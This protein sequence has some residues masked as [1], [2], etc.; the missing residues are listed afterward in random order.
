MTSQTILFGGS[1]FLGPIILQKYPEII[2]V[3]RTIPPKYIKNRH[4]NLPS[5]EQLSILNNLEF[6]KVIFLIGNSN[7]HRINTTS[8]MGIDYNV[9]PLKK[10]LTY[11][12]KRKLKKFV[13]FTTMLLYDVNKM[14]L[15]CDET[16]PINPFIN[17]YV[18]SKY[19]AEEVTKFYKDKVPII[20]VRLS[21][22]YGPTKL[23][24]P[25]VVPQLMHGVLKSDNPSVWTTK[26][27]R[28][29][30]YAEDASDAILKLLDTDYTGPVN[31]G[32][33]QMNS[34]G[35]IVDILSN[36]SGKQIKVL[37]KPATGPMKYVQDITLLKRLTNWQPAHTLEEGLTETY[38]TMKRWY[39][40]ERNAPGRI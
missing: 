22:I 29:F 15:P 12:Q 32:S 2:S 25:D 23:E 34:V 19:L 39:D 5:L 28:D 33:G 18:F 40:E 37:D 10:A 35:R 38:N 14:T 7:H 6:D 20:N 16:Q 26:P 31:V 8:T 30:V 9:T 27:F 3:G 24:R 4:I 36:I 11:F 17:D 21:N 13:A 1:G